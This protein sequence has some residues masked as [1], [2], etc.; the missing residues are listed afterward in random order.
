MGTAR[1]TDG[2][3][4]AGRSVRE[5]V[6]FL[7]LILYIGSESY[8]KIRNKENPLGRNREYPR[9]VIVIKIIFPGEAIGAKIRLH[10]R[11]L[12]KCMFINGLS[13]SP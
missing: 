11:K 7:Q 4:N 5:T 6:F 10:G 12:C 9:K 2:N 3:G 1:K 13:P 8:Y